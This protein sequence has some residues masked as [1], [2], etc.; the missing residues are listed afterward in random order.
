MNTHNTSVGVLSDSQIEKLIQNARKIR[1]EN[2]V[3]RKEIG[4]LKEA[5]L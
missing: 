5:S 4:A 1:A 2:I 3:L